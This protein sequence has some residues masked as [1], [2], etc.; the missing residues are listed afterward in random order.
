MSCTYLQ[1]PNDF[2][3]SCCEALCETSRQAG[4]LRGL[5][6]GQEQNQRADLKGDQEAGLK[7]GATLSY[8]QEDDQ[9]VG[10]TPEEGLDT[11]QT[12]EN[13]GEGRTS[14]RAGQ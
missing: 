4:V 6:V 9:K 3:A 2:L 1:V 7:G 13:G 11:E 10:V 14:W 12:G 5:R 8:G